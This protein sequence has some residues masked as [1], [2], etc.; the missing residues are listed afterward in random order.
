[1]KRVQLLASGQVPRVRQSNGSVS[2]TIQAIVDHE[3][4]AIDL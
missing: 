3:V 2:L 4:I 1:V